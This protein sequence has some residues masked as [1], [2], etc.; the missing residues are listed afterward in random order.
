MR[1][2]EGI[3]IPPDCPVTGHAEGPFTL[4][5][6]HFHCSF[7]L[8]GAVPLTFKADDDTR[9]ALDAA[10][11]RHDEALFKAAVLRLVACALASLPAASTCASDVSPYT[12]MALEIM[13]ECPGDRLANADLARRL[14]ISE[15][16]LLRVFRDNLGVS[17]QKEYM[18][19]RL[20]HAATLLQ[21]T[22]KSIEQIAEECGFCDRN[23]F[24]RIFSREWQVPPATY[25]HTATPL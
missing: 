16:T 17:P 23:H 8:A 10:V 6:A 12:T 2:H 5:Y 21:H 18:R 11:A 15:A 25:R 9:R 1:A 24:T 4:F 13:K 22:S 19:L 14:R 20:A 7:H 3:V